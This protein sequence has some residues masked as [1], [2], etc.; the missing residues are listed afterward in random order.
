MIEV[1]LAIVAAIAGAL[2]LALFSREPDSPERENDDI[3]KQYDDEGEDLDTSP[4][5]DDID[6]F[7][8]DLHRRGSGESEG[9]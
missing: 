3:T 2:G 4:P 6:D 5:A 9:D 1:L 7:V 8:R